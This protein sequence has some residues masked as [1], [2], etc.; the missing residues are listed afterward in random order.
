MKELM[1][2]FLNNVIPKTGQLFPDMMGGLMRGA[3]DQLKTAVPGALFGSAGNFFGGIGDAIGDFVSNITGGSVQDTVR[4]EAEKHGWGSGSQWNALSWIIGKESSWRP[5]AQNPKSTAYGLF[6]FLNSTWA[7]TGISKTSDP[8]LQ[9]VAGMR[10]IANRYGDPIKAQRFW[11]ANGWYSKGGIVEPLLRDSGGPIPTGTSLV[12]NNTGK[13]EWAF[14][15][16]HVSKLF[17]FIEGLSFD[18]PGS[19]GSIRP[20]HIGHSGNVY[21]DNEINIYATESQGVDELADAVID[22]LAALENKNV[23]G[24]GGFNRV[25]VRSY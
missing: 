8:R 1:D 5:T 22:K 4:R 17:G 24:M 16:S 23:R 13:T 15:D 19:I 14:T 12:Q 10:Y 6:Q 7:G 2:A 25:S 18:T 21:N 9:A 20:V 3:V 11:R